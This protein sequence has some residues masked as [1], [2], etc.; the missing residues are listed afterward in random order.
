MLA[1]L[2]LAR[3]PGENRPGRAWAKESNSIAADPGHFNGRRKERPRWVV[4][5]IALTAEFIEK[6]SSNG[7]PTHCKADKILR[8][9]G[10]RNI[11]FHRCARS[12]ILLDLQDYCGESGRLQPIQGNRPS[13]PGKSNPSV[14]EYDSSS[15]SSACI[16][17]PFADSYPPSHPSFQ[18]QSPTINP[19]RQ[20][21]LLNLHILQSCHRILLY[22]PRVW[23]PT[24]CQAKSRT[25][26][27]F[28]ARKSRLLERPSGICS[29]K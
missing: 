18:A 28:A 11:I 20:N 12:T 29:M 24:S 15:S 3:R 17:R 2:A 26:M 8:M 22:S 19:V 4:A 6:L 5:K 9:K 27:L 25:V 21:H 14:I 10:F 13:P 7:I 23:Q 1:E 16:D